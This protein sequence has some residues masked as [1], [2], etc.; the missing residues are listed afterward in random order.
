MAAGK[1]ALQ[2][3]HD[4]RQMAADIKV[5]LIQGQLDR[6]GDLLHEGWIQK[7]RFGA[8]I[9][10]A[11]IDALYDDLQAAGMRGGK[12]TGAGGGGHMLVYAPFER[13]A[14]VKSAVAAAG[15]RHVPYRIDWIGLRTWEDRHV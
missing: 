1:D 5:S 12:I 11:H 15:G 2:A 8:K 14:E 7:K 6:L 10:N 13:R 4:A 9:T 3:M